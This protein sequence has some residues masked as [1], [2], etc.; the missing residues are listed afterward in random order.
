MKATIFATGLAILFTFSNYASAGVIYQ[1]GTLGP[2]G[3]TKNEVLSQAV[4]AANVS[5]F[6]FVGARFFI[7]EE[8]L[9][10][11]LG[12]HFI[13]GFNDTSFFGAIVRLT[14]SLDFPDSVD[15]ST[16]DV[17][18]VTTLTFP[19]TSDEVF[20]DLTVHL[21]PG[22]YALVFGS[23]L[24]GTTGR[25]SAPTNN[26]DIESPQYII[27]QPDE[28]WF[29]AS[30]FTLANDNFRFVVEGQA[31]PEPAASILML[32]GAICLSAMRRCVISKG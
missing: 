2:T 9:T 28:G 18:G 19:D 13:G 32:F 3:I 30:I 23:G 7:E 26:T 6:N 8:M 31:I 12:G 10:T 4:L 14:D 24:F 20:G 17:I 22:W 15:L 5:S 29:N 11:S 16:P 21:Q 27:G 1:S 25:G